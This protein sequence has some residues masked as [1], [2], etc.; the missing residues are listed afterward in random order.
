MDI[1]QAEETWEIVR[2]LEPQIVIHCAANTQ[3]DY[4]EEHPEETIQVN[5]EGTNNVAKGAAYVGAK[6]IYISTDS[7]FDGQQV[8]YSEDTKPS[9]LNIYARSK[10]LGEEAIHT[11]IADPLIVRT[12]IYGWNALPKHCLAEWV[13]DR[14]VHGQIVSGIADI[15]FSPILVNDLADV[16][17]AMLDADLRGVYHVGASDSCSKFEFARMLCKVFGGNIALVQHTKSAEVDFKANRPQDTSLNVRKV[18]RTLG[19]AMPRIMDGLERFRRLHEAGYV[20][21]LRSGVA[22]EEVTT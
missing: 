19:R 8:G 16:L 15:Y 6:F 18:T 11:H 21:Q 7:V 9:P 14:L 4:C 17:V 22:R 10:L 5:V 20:S 12:N 1:T 2:R 3:V 13:W